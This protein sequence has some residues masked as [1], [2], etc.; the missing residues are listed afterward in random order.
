V[1]I[2]GRFKMCKEVGSTDIFKHL[3]FVE[4][5]LVEGRE[6]IDK[7]LVQ[8]SEKLYK[9][10]EEVLKILAITLNLEETRK[11][12]R[13]ICN[14]MKQSFIAVSAMILKA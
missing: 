3:E 4:K 1:A 12:C 9:V 8:V 2:V 13:R 14:D 10:A 6:L 5:L 11:L 7:D